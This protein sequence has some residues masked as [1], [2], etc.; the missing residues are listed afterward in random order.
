MAQKAAGGLSLS[1]GA[2][3]LLQFTI[4]LSPSYLSLLSA[5]AWL[6]QSPC[7]RRWRSHSRCA[8]M[9]PAETSKVDT[10]PAVVVAK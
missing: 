4:C 10:E 1:V 3:S 5:A 7:A 9:P 2:V 8:T 6:T